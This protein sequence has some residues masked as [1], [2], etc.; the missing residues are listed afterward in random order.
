MYICMYI[1]LS[2]SLSLSQHIHNCISQPLSFSAAVSVP[3]SLSLSTYIHIYMHIQQTGINK[4]ILHVTHVYIH[5]H[6]YVHICMSRH[7][8]S[9][10]QTR[11]PLSPALG[12]GLPVFLMTSW[13]TAP[14]RK[15]HSLGGASHVA[16]AREL[17]YF[18][19]VSSPSF[20][21]LSCACFWNS[22]SMLR[23]SLLSLPNSGRPQRTSDPPVKIAVR[24]NAGV[25]MLNDSL[26]IF[27][28]T[29]VATTVF[30]APSNN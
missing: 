24:I 14:P 22:C 8:N 6:T 5:M 13:A 11:L 19:T 10:F 17:H 9:M 20:A 1:S 4:R 3:L 12:P 18:S 21:K 2:V 27:H 30:V 28:S 7:A 23:C 15:A 29:T 16:D 26:L 25:H